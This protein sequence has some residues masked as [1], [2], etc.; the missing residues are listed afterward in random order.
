MAE[1]FGLLIVGM[2]ALVVL[3]VIFSIAMGIVMAVLGV[4]V[5]LVFRAIDK[6]KV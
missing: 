3:A 5:A 1:A 4:P 2:V 6:K